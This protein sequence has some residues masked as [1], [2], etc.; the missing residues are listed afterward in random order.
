MVRNS[1]V[2]EAL[3]DGYTQSEIAT[4]L[5]FFNSVVSKIASKLQ[6]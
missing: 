2:L 5:K 4:Y 6:K 3:E 1:A